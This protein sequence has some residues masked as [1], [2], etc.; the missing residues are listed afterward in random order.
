MNRIICVGDGDD[1]RNIAGLMV[2][3]QLAGFPTIP[4]IEIVDGGLGSLDLLLLIEKVERVVFVGAIHGYSRPGV[5]LLGA[6]EAVRFAPVSS[7]R[8]AGLGFLLIAL[9]QVIEEP[10][11]NISIIGIEAPPLPGVIA[12]AATLSLAVARHG[13]SRTRRPLAEIDRIEAVG[14]V[15]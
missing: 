2:Y 15:S 12:Q 9:P 13:A 10:L 3:D 6:E 8:A 7:D 5:V 14:R 4:G 11:S 1:P